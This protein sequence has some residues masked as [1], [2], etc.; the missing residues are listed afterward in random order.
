M[1][2][3]KVSKR[4]RPEK[5]VQI[6]IVDML[7]KKGWYVK[8]THGNM[9]QSGMPDLIATHSRY[10]I[11]FIE[12]KLPKMKGSHFTVA[13]LEDFPKFVANGCGIWILVADTE[14]EYEK[15]FKPCNWWQYLNM[16]RGV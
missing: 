14:E 12:V 2:P 4:K 16:F 8:E 11:R 5:I 1:D 3:C 6:K 9:Y 13:Q 15:L 7:L 10:G